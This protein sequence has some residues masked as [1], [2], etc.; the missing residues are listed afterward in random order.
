MEQVTYLDTHTA[1]WLYGGEINKLSAKAINLIENSQTLI[2]PI[3]MLELEYLFEIR[4]LNASGKQVVERLIQLVDLQLCDLPFLSVME[5]AMQQ[6]WTRD[7]FDRIIV[8]HAAVRS[9]TLIT[10]DQ[11]IQAHY[12]YAFW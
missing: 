9:S 12:P 8:G 6:T 11:L 1:A 3:V 10:K 7:P 2:S 5:Y 4:R